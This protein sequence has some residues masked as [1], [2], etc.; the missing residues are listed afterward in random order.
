MIKECKKPIWKR[1]VPLIDLTGEEPREIIERPKQEPIKKTSVITKTNVTGV[2]RTRQIGDY[3]VSFSGS[4]SHIQII[5]RNQEIQT[6][7][8]FE[9]LSN[10]FDINKVP[11]EPKKLMDWK[12][13]KIDYKK[14]K[15][16]RKEFLNLIR[17][18]SDQNVSPKNGEITKLIPNTNAPLLLIR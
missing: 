6:L 3:F 9:D 15:V 1:E 4:G 8:F 14:K 17:D 2:N 5:R 11:E 18:Q 10:P 7:P 13:R 12:L 16:D